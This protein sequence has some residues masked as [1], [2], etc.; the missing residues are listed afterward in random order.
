MTR[1]Q[2]ATRAA[3]GYL[4]LRLPDAAWDELE[5]L[6]PELRADP[7][8]L[9]MRVRIYLAKD[10]PADAA[11]IGMGLLCMVPASMTAR[12]LVSEAMERQGLFAEALQV[13][14]G[15]PPGAKWDAVHHY[16]AGRLMVRLGR[17]R[18]GC[19][20]LTKAVELDG[21]IRARILD[22]ETLEVIW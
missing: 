5:D 1:V 18:E 22:D 15:A 4:E 7:D 13:L 10:R 8:V 3:E 9:A 17:T 16:H 20:R 21:A 11:I 12:E 19:D 14:E 2:R 6:E